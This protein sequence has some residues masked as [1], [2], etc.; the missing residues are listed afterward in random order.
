MLDLGYQWFKFRH[1][2]ACL[3]GRIEGWLALKCPR[4]LAARIYIRVHACTAW[5]FDMDKHTF[6]LTM[7][8]WK[9]GKG[10]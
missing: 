6:D 3:P 8:A 1:W 5:D 9:A 4:G 2:K 7:T 10:R